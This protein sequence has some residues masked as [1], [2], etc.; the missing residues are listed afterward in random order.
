MGTARPVLGSVWFQWLA[1]Y[2]LSIAGW[3]AMIALGVVLTIAMDRLGL[4]RVL[5][6]TGVGSDMA[7]RMAGLWRTHPLKRGTLAAMLGV[8]R[9]VE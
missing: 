3:V 5:I 2:N 9:A 6:G 7:R 1:G 8:S 4:L